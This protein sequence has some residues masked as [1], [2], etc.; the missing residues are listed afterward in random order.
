[1]ITNI[2]VLM[3]GMAFLLG[4]ATA[5]MA[6]DPFVGTWK[7]NLSKL[8]IAA[9]PTPKNWTVKIDLTDESY[10][11]VDDVVDAQGTHHT[12]S[13]LPI[14]DGQEHAVTGNAYRDSFAVKRV[15]AYTM[16]ML[17]KK[18]GKEVARAQFVVSKDG[19][20]LTMTTT[21][22]YPHIGVFVYDKQ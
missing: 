17:S 4:L 7:L 16:T 21:G 10:R 13:K 1:M 19:K 6:A 14:A 3:T 5:A 18:G 22:G 2:L 8:K 11:F 20:A 15:D 9:G 12:E